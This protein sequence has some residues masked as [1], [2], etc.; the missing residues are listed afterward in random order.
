MTTVQMDL[1]A[2]HGFSSSMSFLHKNA[3]GIAG[4]QVGDGGDRSGLVRG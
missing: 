3:H 2:R 1:D 4:G